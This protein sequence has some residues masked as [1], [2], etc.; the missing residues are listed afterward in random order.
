MLEA[1]RGRPAGEA[2]VDAVARFLLTPRGLLSA[3][4]DDAAE[5]LAGVA[6]MIATSAALK[7]RQRDIFAHFTVSLADLIAEESRAED[8]DVRPLVAA[9]ALMGVH[10]SLV[11]LVHRRL[12][13]GAVDRAQLAREVKARGKHAVELLR[14]GL[15]DYGEKRPRNG[16]NKAGRRARTRPGAAEL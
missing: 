8:G 12:L 9:H 11:R 1:V 4:D 2:V 16:G 14:N 15:A 6:R 3:E 7:S 10:E 5:H 13:E